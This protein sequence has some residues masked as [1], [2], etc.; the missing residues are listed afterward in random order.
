MGIFNDFLENAKA[1]AV[2]VSEKASDTYDITKLR[3]L[4]SKIE[5]DIKKHYKALGCKCY[6]LYKEDQLEASL[7]AEDIS[8][9]DELMEQRD[10][11]IKQICDAK[12]LKRCPVCNKAQSN[13]NQYCC[14]CG[15]QI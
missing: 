15:T 2:K 9:I 12:N 13:D 8:A 3:A 14:D 11:V 7:I 5:N 10:N 1:V 4:K 6:K